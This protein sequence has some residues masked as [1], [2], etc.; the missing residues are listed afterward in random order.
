MP[1]QEDAELVQQID[2]EGDDEKGEGIARGGDDGGKD[3]ND[4]NGVATVAGHEFWFEESHFR[5]Q[6][7]KHREFEHNAHNQ[8]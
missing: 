4:D 2:G 7:A 3:E 6:P 5:Q 8:A 1:H